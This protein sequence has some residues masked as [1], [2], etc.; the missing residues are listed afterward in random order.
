M[1]PPGGARRRAQRRRPGQRSARAARRDAAVERHRLRRSDHRR[2]GPARRR[3]HPAAPPARPLVAPLHAGAVLVVAR[4]GGRSGQGPGGRGRRLG[5]RVDR[6]ARA[7]GPP[8]AQPGAARPH[9][10]PALSETERLHELSL[11]DGLTQ[12]ANHRH[13]QDRLRDEFRRAQRYDDPLALILI[14]LDHFKDVN[15]RHGHLVGDQVLKE[16]AVAIKKSVRETDFVARYGG[17]EFA[18]V[19]PKTQPRRRAHRGRAGVARRRRAQARR[20]AGVRHHRL[21]RASGYPSRTIVSAEQMVRCADEAL[22]RAKREGRNK[23]AIYQAETFA[24]AV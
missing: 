3:L 19:L 20:L 9:R 22:Y 13:F 21:A 6:R 15:D 8:D 23:I 16:V 5:T 17:E 12:I 24:E 11:T 4:R 14:D 7:A 2:R 1:A 10:R 18:V